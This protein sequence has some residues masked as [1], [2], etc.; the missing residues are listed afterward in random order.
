MGP[1]FGLLTLRLRLLQWEETRDHFR[2]L[3][4]LLFTWVE[5]YLSFNFPWY[6]PEK[7]G[8]FCLIF[9]HISMD[10]I[11]FNL[12]RWIISFSHPFLSLIYSFNYSLL[13]VYLFVY[14]LTGFLLLSC[15]YF[16]SCL[17]VLIYLFRIRCSLLN[18]ANSVY[19]CVQFNR[20][21]NIG[22]LHIGLLLSTGT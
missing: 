15:S 10:F 21:F 7:S 20:I 22:C 8:T 19:F 3:A 18:C 4:S 12:F 9:R 11:L 13:F 2:E 16:S 5:S 14:F 1:W 6:F 17:A